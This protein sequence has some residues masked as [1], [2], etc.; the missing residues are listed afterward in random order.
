MFQQSSNANLKTSR[1][2]DASMA[3]PPSKRR[4]LNEVISDFRLSEYPSFSQFHESTEIH[5]SHPLH[6]VS[7]SVVQDLPEPYV[8][9]QDSNQYIDICIEK[10]RFVEYIEMFQSDG[11]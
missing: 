5:S 6:H 1:G 2:L 3:S 9:K 4:R 10:V 11:K 8:K 7:S